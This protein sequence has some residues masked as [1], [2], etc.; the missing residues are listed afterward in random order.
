[1]RAKSGVKGEKVF[2]TGDTED[3]EMHR[4]NLPLHQPLGRLHL[5]QHG[6]CSSIIKVVVA[7]DVGN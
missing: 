7:T 3:T 5:L 1:V 6:D 4:V 2:T